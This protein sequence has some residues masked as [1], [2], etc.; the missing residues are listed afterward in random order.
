MLKLREEFGGF[1]DAHDIEAMA[2]PD[3]GLY[4]LSYYHAAVATEA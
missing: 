3:S 4:D 2:Q 1:E